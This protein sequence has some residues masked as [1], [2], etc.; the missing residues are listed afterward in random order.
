MP[1]E[2]M[3][4]VSESFAFLTYPRADDPR[5][6]SRAEGAR[7]GAGVLTLEA[8]SAGMSGVAAGAHLAA[9]SALLPLLTPEEL[10]DYTVVS[11][12][13][14]RAPVEGRP[15]EITLDPRAAAD[16]DVLALAWLAALT[17]ARGGDARAALRRITTALVLLPPQMTLLP[18]TACDAGGLA[19]RFLAHVAE[20]PERWESWFLGQRR[21]DLPYDRAA[22]HAALAIPDPDAQRLALHEVVRRYDPAVEAAN[23]ARIAA[24]THAAGE[25]LIF[26]R[27]SRAFHNQGLLFAHA[28]YVVLDDAVRAVGD[29]LH[30]A[31]APHD[32]LVGAADRLRILLGAPEAP[33]T[34]LH[35]A[36]ELLE[37]AIL[38]EQRRFRHL[39]RNI[40]TYKLDPDRVGILVE[41]AQ[42]AFPML[43]AE[44]LAFAVFL[45]RE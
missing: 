20:A 8:G 42:R 10:G 14:H 12:R 22:V 2:T 13:D 29:A 5:C 4:T 34:A 21:L 26:G 45:E 43:K 40:Y 1:V 16:P 44:L 19:A 37:E 41:S 25:E 31:C 33:A 15:G 17:V 36:L 7:V 11:R 39:V 23:I 28:G 32:A 3:P 30:A 35:G 6:A 9:L 38:D 27:M 24:E 18:D